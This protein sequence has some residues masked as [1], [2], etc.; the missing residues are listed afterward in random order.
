MREFKY[1]GS[2]HAL[3][4]NGETITVNT[5]DLFTIVAGGDG[6]VDG[7]TVTETHLKQIIS[8]NTYDKWAVL[9]VKDAN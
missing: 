4:K 2:V 1:D 6:L 9:M 8:V 7:D 5:P 3:T